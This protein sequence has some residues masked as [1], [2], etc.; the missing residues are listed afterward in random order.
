MG[1]G[2]DSSNLFPSMPANKF[3][4]MASS[5]KFLGN[6][7]IFTQHFIGGAIKWTLNGDGGITA[8]IQMRVAHQKYK[9]DELTEVL[10]KGHAHGTAFTR[11]SNVD[12]VWKF[13]G[14]RPEVRWTEGRYDMI[15][16]SE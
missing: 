14:L 3:I 15:F 7:R 11:F 13:A 12:G 5:P 1:T 6:P 8:S 10:Y 9:D 4:A 16:R 2:D